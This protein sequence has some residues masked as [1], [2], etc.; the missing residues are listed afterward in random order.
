MKKRTMSLEEQE[1]LI[2]ADPLLIQFI[3]HP[4]ES[5]QINAVRSVKEAILYIDNPCSECVNIVAW[6]IPELLKK[7]TKEQLKEDHVIALLK[8]SRN[9]NIYQY[10][11]YQ[12]KE[13]QERMLKEDYAKFKDYIDPDDDILASYF[14][15]HRAEF[16]GD[17]IKDEIIEKVIK[18]K[19]TYLD[20]VKSPSLR[21][22]QFIIDNNIRVSHHTF[23][24]LNK[25]IKKQLITK[26]GHCF[27]WLEEHE[28]TEEMAK[29]AL[30]SKVKNYT[31]M[32]YLKEVPKKIQIE[33][34]KDSTYYVKYIKNLDYEV[35]KLAFEKNVDSFTDMINPHLDIIKEYFKVRTVRTLDKFHSSKET[36]WYAITKN[37]NAVKYIK[38]PHL[39]I[40]L[41]AVKQHAELILE[42]AHQ[43]R[44]EIAIL[45]ALKKKIEVKDW[46]A[47]LP[48]VCKIYLAF[49]GENPYQD[50]LPHFIGRY[51]ENMKNKT[52]ADL[53]LTIFK[54]LAESSYLLSTSKIK[55][56]VM[57]WIEKG[58]LSTEQE[59]FMQELVEFHQVAK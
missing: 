13:I 33:A 51:M 19:P 57:E 7:L 52:I 31:A 44:S 16:D 47:E 45:E 18:E 5:V 22:Q 14:I 43:Y 4:E 20:E 49:V 55:K 56:E 38:N 37:I 15:K 54:L 6:T 46:F 27:N 30:Q 53:P 8:Y 24:K 35:Q 36:Q 2:K 59:Q 3:E 26:D 39:D 41:E 17:N 28:K 12:T 48:L 9:K 25:N 50:Y 21:I 29:K 1:K 23:K 32:Q 58:K 42:I 40:Q 11:P 10:L 34:I